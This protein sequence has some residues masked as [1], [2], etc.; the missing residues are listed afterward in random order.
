MGRLL[1]KNTLLLVVLAQVFPRHGISRVGI[2]IQS[3]FVRVVHVVVVH[4][5]AGGRQRPHATCGGGCSSRF[6]ADVVGRHFVVA[7]S[8]H[9]R[10]FFDCVDGHGVHLRAAVGRGVDDG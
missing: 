10:P 6:T 8:N 9:A 4:V 3:M 7:A 1:H 2:K 5:G